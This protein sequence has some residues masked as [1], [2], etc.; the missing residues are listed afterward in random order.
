MDIAQRSGLAGVDWLADG[1]IGPYAD[2]FKRRLTEHRYAAHTIASYTAGISH[3]A[4]WACTRHLPL[5]RIDEVSVAI[6]L[7]DH[8]PSCACTRPARRDRADHSSALGHLLIVL[9]A[10]GAIAL[11]VVNTTPV[12]EELRCYD[13]HMDHVRGLAPKTRTTALRIVGR[14]LMERFGTSGP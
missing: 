14:L 12:D 13:A 5:R 2:A 4:R 3:F 10:Q 9:R 11:P 6:F 8:L 1:L 7:D